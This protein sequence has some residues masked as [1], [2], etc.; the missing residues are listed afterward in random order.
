[1]AFA[2]SSSSAGDWTFSATPPTSV[3]CWISGETI[4][5]CPEACAI[6]QA[7]VAAQLDVRYGCDV[8]FVPQ[9]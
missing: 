1:M 8:G 5:L 7:D 4:F 6:V 3:L 2:A 9:G